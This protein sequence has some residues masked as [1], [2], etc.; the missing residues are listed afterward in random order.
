LTTGNTSHSYNLFSHPDKPLREHLLRVGEKAKGFVE[1]LYMDLTRV[2][3]SKEDLSEICWILGVTH[4]YGKAT[5]FFQEYLLAENAETKR[6]LRAKPETKHA[7]LSALLAYHLLKQRFQGHSSPLRHIL[8]L[9]GYAVVKRHHG[10]LENLLKEVDDPGDLEV[11]KKQVY[12]I[13]NE[14]DQEL[15]EGIIPLKTI[16][17]F[18]ENLEAIYNDLLRQRS[19]LRRIKKLGLE[20][21]VLSLF[22]FSVLISADKEEA[23]GLE[24]EYEPETLSEGLIGEYRRLLGWD[25]PEKDL[26]E[27]RNRIYME[28]ERMAKNLD[29]SERILSLNTPTGSGKTFTGLNFALKLRERIRRELGFTPRIFYCV[30]FVSIIDQN[31]K[32]FHDAYVRVY[33]KEPTSNVLLKHHHLSD[34][35]YSYGG[36]EFKQDPLESLFLIEGWN[37]EVVF[38]TFYQ[39][40]HTLLSNRNRALRKYCKLANAVVLLDEVQGIPHKYWLLFRRLLYVFS[41]FFQTYFIFMTATMPLIFQRED[42]VELVSGRK[43]Y[44]GFF[45]RVDLHIESEPLSL[46]EFV[47]KAAEQVGSDSCRSYLFVMNTIRSSQRLFKGLKGVVPREQ[48]IY[49]STRV[50]PKERLKRIKRVRER[51]SRVV[52]VSTQLVEAGVDIDLDVVYRDLAPLDSIV[53][54]SGRCNRNFRQRGKV[55]VVNLRDDRRSIYEYIYGASSILIDKTLEVLAGRSTV[56]EDEFIELMDE[57]YDRLQ[58]SMSD[59]ES[60]TLL[61]ALEKLRFEELSK[62]KL[63]ENDYPKVDVFVEFD[64]EAVDVWG[65]YCQVRDIRDWAERRRRYLRI[66]RRFLDYVVSVPIKFK[67]MVGFSEENGIGYISFEEVQEGRIYD[68]DMGF[69]A[70]AEEKTLEIL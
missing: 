2:G 59:D 14:R 29:L 46:E 26:D 20:A 32:A 50:P 36:D 30:S 56:S 38:T 23:S 21:S 22:C 44:Y 12:A 47:E 43:E 6:K 60:R 65:E 55:Y 39:L 27:L 48:L 34:I 4:D 42:V 5:S 70:D 1:D 58:E 63:I 33:G 8:P 16:T 24:V 13:H 31:Y 37:S 68:V 3:L 35:L 15:Y 61:R 28:A 9:I 54:S 45:D 52:V 67:N 10:N 19:A 7:N 11:F 41:E 51:C 53:Q 25:K 49:L 66:K 18:K 64:R 40:F 17:D 69:K 57:F 62:F